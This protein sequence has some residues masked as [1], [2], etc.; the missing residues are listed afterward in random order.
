MTA[1]DDW[2]AVR[3]RLACADA[4]LMDFDGPVCSVF[5]GFPASAVADQLR[6]TLVQGGHGDFPDLIQNS[7]DPFDI[8]IHAAAIGDE[9]A[10][11][12]EAAFA[13]RECEAI[14]WAKPTTGAHDFIREW[15][16]SGRS[17]A[18]VSNNSRVAIERYVSLHRLERQ[19]SVIAAREFTD[20]TLLKPSPHLVRAALDKTGADPNLSVFIGDSISDIQAGRA[21]GVVCVG[22]ANRPGKILRLHSVADLVVTEYPR[23]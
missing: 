9:E 19:I 4:L 23:T 11:Y 16:R 13:A 15:H 14:R 8:F 18:I 12:I 17:V 21:A 1:V 6:E 5:A 20:P 2:V 22:F 10:R 3:A 7:R